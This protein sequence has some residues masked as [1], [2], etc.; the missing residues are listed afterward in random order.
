MIDGVG[1]SVLDRPHLL[2][3]FERD[4][5]EA[6]LQSRPVAL[7][8]GSL[9]FGEEV[10]LLRL[11]FGDE[12]GLQRLSRSSSTWRMSSTLLFPLGVD[13]VGQEA[14]TILGSRLDRR[15]NGIALLIEAG[16]QR[17]E[18]RSPAARRAWS[19]AAIDAISVT[20][21]S[22]RNPAVAQIAAGLGEFLVQAMVV[23]ARDHQPETTTTAG[24][25]S[26]PSGSE[27]T[28]TRWIFFTSSR[29]QISARS[30]RRLI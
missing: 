30:R 3:P 18:R 15:Q 17:R 8:L 12:F 16:S 9:V 27:R 14:Q 10:E 7:E 11:P 22:R 13:R 2:F 24:P 5:G 25:S 26:R 6:R 29:A 28:V 23:A 20:R 21:S 19:P 4:A 1:I